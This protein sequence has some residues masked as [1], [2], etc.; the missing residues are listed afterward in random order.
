MDL[1]IALGNLFG[2][3]LEHLPCLRHRLLVRTEERQ[4]G[5][6]VCARLVIEAGRSAT[7][8]V[9]Y[10]GGERLAS[11]VTGMAGLSKTE[12]SGEGWVVLA[13]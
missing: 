10:P 8:R 5:E 12:R 13:D 2:D 11:I 9:G 4:T 3:R 7:M 1:G 6:K